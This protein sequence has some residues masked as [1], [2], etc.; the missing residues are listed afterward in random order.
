MPLLPLPVCGCP[1]VPPVPLVGAAIKLM[2]PCLPSPLQ[3]GLSKEKERELN[4]SIQ[5][6]FREWLQVRGGYDPAEGGVRGG[7][8]EEEG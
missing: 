6:H 4:D 5:A 2:R 8:W 3:A 1:L 7:E